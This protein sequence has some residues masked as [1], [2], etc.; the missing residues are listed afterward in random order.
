MNQPLR[1][2]ASRPSDHAVRTLAQQS[3]LLSVPS[4]ARAMPSAAADEIPLSRDSSF[5]SL[6]HRE[7]NILPQGG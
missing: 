6:Q 1:K 4:R 7:G 2:C 3:M 5:P